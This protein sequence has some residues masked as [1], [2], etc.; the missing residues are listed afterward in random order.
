[1]KNDEMLMPEK[2]GS[3]D[4]KE[5]LFAKY[6]ALKTREPNEEASQHL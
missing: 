5:F 1:M 2:D 3:S 4:D 6:N